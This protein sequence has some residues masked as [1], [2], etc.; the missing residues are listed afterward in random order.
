MTSSERIR[1]FP[2]SCLPRSTHFRRYKEG[3]KLILKGAESELPSNLP[4]PIKKGRDNA[5]AV[6]AKP[7]A[8]G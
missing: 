1:S 4:K 5:T 2:R 3:L 7:T 6:I 8:R